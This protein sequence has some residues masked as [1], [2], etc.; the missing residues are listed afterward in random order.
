M[1]I[2]TIAKVSAVALLMV[3]VTAITT[4]VMA[5]VNR[6]TEGRLESPSPLVADPAGQHDGATTNHFIEP[7]QVPTI[8]GGPLIQEGVTAIT[9]LRVDF[10]GDSFYRVSGN[11]TVSC[12]VPG[13][14]FVWS[15]RVRDPVQRKFVA[16]KTYDDRIFQIPGDQARSDRAFEDVLPIDL[17][18]GRYNVELV[19]YR[20]P[21]A[22]VESLTNPEIRR[23]Q[24]MA[25]NSYR[26]TI[27]AE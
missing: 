3:A 13:A 1:R 16:E 18:A 25:K 11:A 17:P 22:G 9:S 12:P 10:E 4:A 26:I 20:V 23:S 21:D 5:R 6:S 14:E 8:A 15:V 2:G 27:D 24:L 7:G 19:I